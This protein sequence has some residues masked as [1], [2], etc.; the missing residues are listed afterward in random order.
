MPVLSVHRDRQ[1][2]EAVAASSSGEKLCDRGCT[3]LEVSVGMPQ[4]QDRFEGDPTDED[5]KTG[6]PGQSR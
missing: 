3:V 4:E 2:E 5:G 6:C 1:R